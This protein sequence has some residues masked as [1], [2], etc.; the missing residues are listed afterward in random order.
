[1]IWIIALLAC[2]DVDEAPAEVL[3]DAPA[4]S[5]CADDPCRAER[6]AKLIQEDFAA[7]L[8]MLQAIRDPVFKL[9]GTNRIIDTPNSN[10][11][12]EQGKQVCE[13]SKEVLRSG[14]CER[15]FMSPHLRDMKDSPGRPP[16]PPKQDPNGG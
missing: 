11:T 12:P 15:R 6:V 5:A 8:E 16:P 2:G 9:Q 14:L 4:E 1:V 10:L 3:A 7:G 13:E